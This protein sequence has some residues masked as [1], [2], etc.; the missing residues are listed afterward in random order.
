MTPFMNVGLN[1]NFGTV[2]LRSS[3]SIDTLVI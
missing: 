1:D 3:G 2:K